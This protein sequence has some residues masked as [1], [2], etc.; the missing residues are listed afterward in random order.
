MIAAN[1]ERVREQIVKACHR[2]NRDPSEV[3]IVA[4]TKERSVYQIDEVIASGLSD[5]G[6]NKI[7]EAQIKFW[8]LCGEGRERSHFRWHM[9]GHLQTNKVKDAVQIFDLIHS[10]DSLKLAKTIDNQAAKYGKIQEVLIEVNTSG[11]TE[12]FGCAPEAV[13][14][15]VKEVATFKNIKLNGLMTMAPEVANPE[16]ARPYFRMLRELRDTIY[17]L[18]VTLP[19]KGRPDL[20]PVLSMGMSNDFE[21]AVEEG[22]TMVR[23]GRA[24][25]GDQQKILK[26]REKI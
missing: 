7:Q 1:I 4:V 12:K 10:V 8:E 25:L 22:A 23:I 20:S 2:V 14:G 9:I 3:T 15:L 18:P 24:I 13:E 17:G 26:L 19:A 16:D 5:I 6:E 21:V 11:E